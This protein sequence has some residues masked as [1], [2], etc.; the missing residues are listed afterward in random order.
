MATLLLQS[1]VQICNIHGALQQSEMVSLIT[2]NQQHSNLRVLTVEHKDA[3]ATKKNM[4]PWCTVKK[5]VG[6][7]KQNFI[8]MKYRTEKYQS[9]KSSSTTELFKRNC[10]TQNHLLLPE[11]G[12]F[13]ILTLCGVTCNKQKLAHSAY[14]AY[15]PQQKDANS[16]DKI[17]AA[18]EGGANCYFCCLC[19]KPLFTG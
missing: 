16:R 3:I 4:S 9:D 10:W 7:L 8:Q 5:Y 13:R 14:T 12:F 1:C 17:A 11:R 19:Y 6:R 18:D 2:L 15:A